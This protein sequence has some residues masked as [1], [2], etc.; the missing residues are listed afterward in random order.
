METAQIAILI[1]VVSACIAGISLGWNIYRDVIIKPKV[2]IIFGVK[3]IVTPGSNERPE[4]VII[5]ATNFGP[6]ATTISM[7]QVRYAPLWR[8]L[9]RK[10]KNAV[11]IHDYENPLSGQ[12]PSKLEVGDKIDLILPYDE[13]CF[14]NEEWT[15]V[16][17]WDY[18]GKSHWAKKR[19]L[20]EARERWLNDFGNQT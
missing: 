11:I 8:R 12:L 20:K 3:M 18:F 7:I 10:A 1:S 17:V 19:Q 14:L 4:Y 15:H 6:G 13:N 5:T 9:L 2:D 16:G